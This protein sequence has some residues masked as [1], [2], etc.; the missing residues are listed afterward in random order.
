MICS[1]P[2][3]FSGSE[4]G[5]RARAF[6][7][8]GELVLSASLFW[9]LLPFVVVAPVAVVVI[10]A[11]GFRGTANWGCDC[12]VAFG[13]R[14]GGTFCGGVKGDGEGEGVATWAAGCC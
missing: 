6:G 1:K 8:V 13:G 4:L 10:V 5:R 14:G 12:A 3:I 11:L 7:L 9:I 2:S